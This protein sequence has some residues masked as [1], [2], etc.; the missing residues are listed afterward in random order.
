MTKISNYP[1]KDVLCL[2]SL[3]TD[4]RRRMIENDYNPDD[5]IKKLKGIGVDV[6]DLS[7]QSLS[8]IEQYKV[9]IIICHHIKSQDN[10]ALV[11][12]DNTHLPVDVFVQAIST[13]FT[14]LLDLA[15]CQSREMAYEIKALSKNPDA[16]KIQYAEEATDVEFRLCFIYSGLLK[17][18]SFN[19][20]DDYKQR[21]RKAYLEAIEEAEKEQKEKVKDPNS[22]PE[23]T[24]LGTNETVTMPYEME[25]E[26]DYPITV[27]I[28][29][30]DYMHVN[31]NLKWEN[32]GTSIRWDIS[33]LALTI[34]EDYIIALTFDSDNIQGAGEKCF[35]WEGDTIIRTF[36]IK[37]KND[38]N[39]NELLS[40]I[41]IKNKKT[42][43][44]VDDNCV[45]KIK[46]TNRHPEIQPLEG[47][48]MKEILQENVVEDYNKFNPFELN[49]HKQIDR[50]GIYDYLRGRKYD[51]KDSVLSMSYEQFVFF[52]DRGQMKQI[53]QSHRHIDDILF[54]VK[55]LKKIYSNGWYEVA[56]KSLGVEKKRV[57]QKF[58]TPTFNH[59]EFEK[60]FFPDDIK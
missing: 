34:D 50:L 32:E 11:L 15:I 45:R 14:G 2:I 18:F 59:R 29:N 47:C 7:I 35:T 42:G 28:H 24:K 20:I 17:N 5:A 21:Y 37:V 60:R 41:T 8:K 52:L 19:P 30:N 25:K 9:V 22:L 36:R 4:I 3:T 43:E 46:V 6:C 31:N 33:S 55:K 57:S 44:P 39:G 48:E 49:N 56:R 40:Y 16:L 26:K 27:Y 38:F 13:E 54:L 10:D 1:H 58:P 12:S 23:G 53:Y 51:D